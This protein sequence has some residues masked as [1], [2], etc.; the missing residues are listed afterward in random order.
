LKFDFYSTQLNEAY[1]EK[2]LSSTQ[3]LEEILQKIN[4]KEN[5][6]VSRFYLVDPTGQ[7]ID[8]PA[9]VPSM[10]LFFPQFAPMTLIEGNQFDSIAFRVYL[11][12]MFE[13][14]NGRIYTELPERQIAALKVTVN[15]QNYIAGIKFEIIPMEV[16]Y[17]FIVTFIVLMLLNL[18][19][20]YF[21]SRSITSDI[22]NVADRMKKISKGQIID[23]E[24][25]LPISSNDEMA[26]LVVA[27]NLI[28]EREKQNIEGI[29]RNQESMMEQERLAVLGHLMSGIAHNLR[30]PI[31]SI[32]GGIEGL[33]D[34]V[35]EYE[36]S[37]IDENVTVQDHQEIA[38][39]MKNWLERLRPYTSYMSDIIAVVRE[40]TAPMSAFAVVTFTA[41][42]VSRRLLIL[43]EHELR[44]RRCKLTSNVII[45]DSCTMEGPLS[46]LIQVLNNLI[47]NAVD[48]YDGNPGEVRVDFTYNDGYCDIAIIDQGKGMD[49]QVKEKVF[50]EMITTKGSKGTGLGIF[51]SYSNIRGRF[52]GD[53]RF[54]SKLGEGTTFH[55]LIPCKHKM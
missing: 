52:N 17:Y 29:K 22:S 50:H 3:Q 44:K 14:N 15:G 45:D 40:Q 7:T 21:L 9:F 47:L 51:M 38:K 20:L 49:D 48:S 16:F 8:D 31:M 43:M 53:M 18:M 25:K 42:E 13:K 39:E 2:E 46:M 55:V 32:S 41:N 12:F 30:T 4:V 6:Q 54:D 5:D 33:S 34:L 27:Y 26:D 28:Q 23:F 19:V 35:R 24:E 1:V 11:Q 37:V 36:E 10:P